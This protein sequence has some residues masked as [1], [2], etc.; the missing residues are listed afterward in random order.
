MITY[1]VTAIDPP[2]GIWVKH[3]N[4]VSFLESLLK[5]CVHGSDLS[6]GQFFIS[7]LESMH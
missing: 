5:H 6:G 7:V 3:H 1:C 4:A 2:V